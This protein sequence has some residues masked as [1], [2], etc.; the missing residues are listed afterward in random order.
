MNVHT[1]TML[2]SI[3][4]SVNLLLQVTSKIFDVIHQI[5]LRNQSHLHKEM[6]ANCPAIIERI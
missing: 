2:V 3:L 5:Q 4:T 1:I 6:C